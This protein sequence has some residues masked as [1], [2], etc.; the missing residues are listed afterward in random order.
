MA[1]GIAVALVAALVAAFAGPALGFGAPTE[2]LFTAVAML[3]AGPGA[4]W[5]LKR[6]SALDVVVA[7]TLVLIAGALIPIGLSALAHGRTI[8]AEIAAQVRVALDINVQAALAQPGADKASINTLADLL[9]TWTAPL[10]PTYLVYTM[11]LAALL[12]VRA[13]AWV[14][15]KSAQEVATLPPLHELD[16]SFHLVWPAIAGL[17]LLAAATYFKQPA[18]ALA[19]VGL[20]LLLIVRPALFFQGAAAFSALYRRIKVGRIGRTVGFVFLALSELVIPSVSVVGI[21]DLFF[22]LRKLP[23]GNAGGQVIEG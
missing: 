21:G 1:T 11:G 3:A 7:L 15:K 14:G 12:S 5:A 9:R 2:A 8:L 10:M 20:N 19:A 22:N 23:R 18:G 6:R 13:V 17:A 16:L 4:V